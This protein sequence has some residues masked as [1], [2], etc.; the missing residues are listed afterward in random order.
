MNGILTTRKPW[1][2]MNLRD[3]MEDLLGR[4]WGDAT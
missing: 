1:G 3:E 2:T 4:F